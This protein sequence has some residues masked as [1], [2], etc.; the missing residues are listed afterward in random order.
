MKR[1]PD[2]IVFFMS[3]FYWPIVLI[4]R[5]V[6]CSTCSAVVKRPRLARTVAPAWARLS[7]IA[8]SQAPRAY[9]VLRIPFMAA[10]G[11]RSGWHGGFR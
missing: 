8:S 10:S 6:A 1:R 4:I 11:Q 2:L 3:L 9:G 7:P 5:S